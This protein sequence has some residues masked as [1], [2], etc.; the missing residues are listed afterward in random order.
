MSP[1]LAELLAI[2]MA[3]SVDADRR[4]DLA[5]FENDYLVA[6]SRVSDPSYVISGP[7]VMPL[8]SFVK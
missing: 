6:L 1:L 5:V 2:R 7:L 3:T 8:M 4:L